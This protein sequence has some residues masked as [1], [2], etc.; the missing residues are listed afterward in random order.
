MPGLWKY[1][2]RWEPREPVLFANL[3]NNQWNTNYP[4]WIDGS[5]SASV[6]LWT[7]AS[8]ASEEEALFTP[9]WE[10]RQ[11]FL[12]GYANGTP[13]NLPVSSAGISLSRKGIRLTAFCPNPDADQ[14]VDGTL[15]RVW[16][17]SGESGEVKLTLPSG[18]KATRAQPVNLR[19]EKSGKPIRIRQD[20]LKFN[21]KAYAPAS[22]VLN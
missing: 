9:G 14:G 4:L 12:T 5:W 15:V 8:G 19:G 6:R 22:F 21:L 1:T 3:Y 13:G 16:E 20:S 11:D 7:V 18:F 10:Q 17:Q 2:P